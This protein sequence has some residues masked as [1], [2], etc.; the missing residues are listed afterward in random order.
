MKK[1]IKAA[2]ILLALAS[3]CTVF[4]RS[5]DL[6][7][8][9]IISNPSLPGIGENSNKAQQEK[10]DNAVALVSAG[11]Y[12]EAYEIFEALGDFGNAKAELAK[13]HYVV[14]KFSYTEIEKDESGDEV[15]SY[16]EKRTFDKNNFP[17]QFIEDDSDGDRYIEDYTYDDKGNLLQSIH[18]NSDGDKYIYKYTYDADGNCIKEIRT[19]PDGE[20]DTTDYTYDSHGNL[21]KIFYF[22]S[23][24]SE[25]CQM[26]YKFVYIPVEL[27]E[28]EFEEMY[29][30][31]W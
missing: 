30:L 12:E 2:S 23:D 17:K 4:L 25:S 9:P 16:T 11:R 22:S 19:D 26:E 13:F 6:G 14:T 29:G 28:E 18:T 8:T 1:S 15:Y 31:D 7:F 27:T 10:Y 3:C 20:T 21:V 24:Y 5:C